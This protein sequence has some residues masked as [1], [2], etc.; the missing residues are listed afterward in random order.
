M[1][2]LIGPGSPHCR[3][4][5]ITFKTHHTRYESPGKVISPTQRSLLDNT[6]HSQEIT[7]PLAR[8][9]PAI[10]ATERPQTHALHREAAGNGHSS[11][12]LANS[13]NDIKPIHILTPYIERCIIIFS[14]YFSLHTPCESGPGVAWWLRRCATSRTISWSITG[15]VTVFFSDIF[16]PTLPWSGGR[17]SP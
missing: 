16:L 11:R 7:T 3:S 14:R 13:L 9:E 1:T 5:T 17:L 6:Q 2:A 15:G 12:L 4:F 8:F 10:P